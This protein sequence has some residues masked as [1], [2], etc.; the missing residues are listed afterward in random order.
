MRIAF[1]CGL[2][3]LLGR[4][5]GDDR[6]AGL[7]ALVARVQEQRGEGAVRIELD[8][9]VLLANREAPPSEAI[10]ALRLSKEAHHLRAL[11]CQS[12]ATARDLVHRVS[13]AVRSR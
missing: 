4:L 1:A 10:A 12:S 3:D 9:G 6:G 2:S 5:A 11:H 8:A 13:R 7:S